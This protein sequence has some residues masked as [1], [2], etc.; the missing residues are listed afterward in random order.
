MRPTLQI[1]VV[2]ADRIPKHVDPNVI[3][4]HHKH[5]DP[6]V[7]TE[8][9]EFHYHF[10]KHSDR[11]TAIDNLQD[12]TSTDCPRVAKYSECKSLV[13]ERADQLDPVMGSLPYQA[14]QCVFPKDQELK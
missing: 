9:Q 8:H 13:K 1:E 3:T 6:Y 11:A 7:I 14:N 12:G 5:T 4:E 10:H 2:E